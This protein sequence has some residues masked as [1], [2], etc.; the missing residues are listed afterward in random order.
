MLTVLPV[1][2]VPRQTAMSPEP[3]VGLT[4]GA[5]VVAALADLAGVVVE[6]FLLTAW[7]SFSVDSERKCDHFSVPG[8][9]L[10]A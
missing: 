8:L 10:K 2:N 5:V 1:L 9:A 4:T 6:C 3:Q 7:R